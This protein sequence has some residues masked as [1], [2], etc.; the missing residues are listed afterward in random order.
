MLPYSR[1]FDQQTLALLIEHDAIVQRYRALFALLD[2]QVLPDPAPDSSRP[3]RRPH[4]ESAYIKALLI[5][6]QEGY[7][8]CSQVRTFLVE[9][10]LLVLELGFRPVLNCDLPYGFDVQ[11][12]VPSERWLREKQRTLDH[13]HLQDLFHATVHA[14]QKEIPELGEVVA[15]DVKHQYAWVRE[16]NLRESIKDRFC[17]ER[18]PRGD[19]DCRV[20]VK[21][22]TNQDQADGSTK[23]R[24]EYLWGYG[25]GIVSATIAGYGDV[26][27]AEFT[28]PFNESDVS[29]YLPL[30][31]QAVAVLGRFPLHVTA[32][33][34]YDAWYVYQ[35]CAHR[36]GIAAIPLNTHGH[37]DVPRDRD[38]VPLCP[39]GLRMHPTYRF[40]HTKGYH[41]QRYRCPLLFPQ[42]TGQTCAHEQFQKDKGCVKDINIE[43]GGLM[44]AMLDR[45]SPLYRA[46]YRQRTS[47]ER[48]NS[49]AKARGIE[50]PKVRQ[51][52]AVRRLNTLTYILINL[53]ALARARTI[54]ASLLTP[55]LGKLT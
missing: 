23:E 35:T 50:R 29:Y 1:L 51:G 20:G 21:S 42:R 45:S 26:V 49:Q 4:P 34:A 3:G 27:L 5:K 9:H 44:R 47:A 22:S 46:V 18:Q 41:A 17:K 2:W 54:N 43:K 12:T 13:C 6:I 30:F 40:L 19:P 10:P 25:S 38:G 24:K 28:Q 14:L 15:F 7:D 36:E 33:A 32:D 11:R 31:I 52:D 37:E 48:I 8:Y 16:N 39:I 55:K 53:K